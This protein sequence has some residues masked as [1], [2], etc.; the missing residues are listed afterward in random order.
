[1][2][3]K[4]ALAGTP[5]T[6]PVFVEDVFSTFL[7]TG[8]GSG[9]Q[10]ITNGIDL[11]GKGGMVWWKTRNNAYNHYLFDT[12]RGATNWLVSNETGAQATVSATLTA[13]NADGFTIGDHSRFNGNTF[14]DV[15][16]TFREQPKFFD[17][18]TW[19]GDDSSNRQI[20]MI[21]QTIPSQNKMVPLTPYIKG[22][23]TNE[24]LKGS[25]CRIYEDD[26]DDNYCLIDVEKIIQYR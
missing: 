1:M 20:R 21:N 13:F 18:V 24:I 14:T 9:S 22:D 16:W 6:P 23:L 11:A 19:T 7:T 2:L 3:N 12:T 25:M 26:Y 15:A 17:V 4:K 5:S 8:T 10:T